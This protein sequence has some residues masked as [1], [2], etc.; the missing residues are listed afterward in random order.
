MTLYQELQ[1]NQAGSKQL[2]RNTQD[3][4]EKARHIAV[5]LF[6]ILLTL[7]FCVAFVTVYT[8]VFGSDNSIVGVVVLLSVMT[9]RFA[10]FGI[11]AP[12]ALSSL[13]VIW[14]IMTFGPRLANAGNLVTELIVNMV[15]IFTLMILGC[16]NVVMFNQSTLL[17]GYLLLYGYDVSGTQYLQRIAGM[18]VGGILT[19]IVF[20]RNHRHQK[21]KRTLRHIFEEFDLHSSRTR[22]QICV[23]LG[24]SSVI[25]FAGLFGLPRAMWAGIACMSVCLPFTEDCVARSGSRWQFNIVGCAIFIVLYLVLPESMYPYIGMIGGIGVGYSAGYAWQTVFNTFGALSIAAGL[26]GMPAAVA[27][28]IGANVFGSAYTVICNKI[29][30]KLADRFVVRKS[31]EA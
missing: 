6:K 25:F 24:V 18:A 27:L 21:Y 12:H 3:K 26:F 5:Y 8:K 10:D 9:F 14:G 17:L 16:H 11:H 13:M 23:T 7:A 20:Y 1:L 2:I 15:C 29:I 31:A 22:W 19:G 28:R 4:K 30:D